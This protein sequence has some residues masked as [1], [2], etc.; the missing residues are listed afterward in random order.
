MSNNMFETNNSN[1]LF[2]D[3]KTNK[4]LIESEIR[5]KFDSSLSQIVIN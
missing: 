3:R 5:H 2:I 1:E 4:V